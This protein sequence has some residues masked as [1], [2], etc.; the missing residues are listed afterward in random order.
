MFEVN[1]LYFE[2]FLWC[3]LFESGSISEAALF[4]QLADFLYLT[5]IEILRLSTRLNDALS[6]IVFIVAY[7]FVAWR[8]NIFTKLNISANFKLNVVQLRVGG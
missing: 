1:F 2:L 8:V 3:V 6:W 7:I 5:N 4:Y